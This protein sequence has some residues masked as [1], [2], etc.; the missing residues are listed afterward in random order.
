MYPQSEIKGFCIWNAILYYHIGQGN[1]KCITE[2]FLLLILLKF[3]DF[4]LESL[5]KC[6]YP[7][8]ILSLFYEFYFTRKCKD[9]ST[10]ILQHMH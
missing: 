3:I 9:E 1:R 7:K 8:I 2:L 4:F 5:N 10:F 6:I